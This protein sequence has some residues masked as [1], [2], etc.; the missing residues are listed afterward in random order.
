M[1][2]F[3]LFVFMI[4]S[5][6]SVLCASK[7]TQ[8]DGNKLF[9]T[10]SG[11]K[12]DFAPT[13]NSLQ[14]KA[15]SGKG[16]SYLSGV[17]S[18]FSD[19]EWEWQL[20]LLFNPSG[21][22]YAR[23]YVASD[24]PDL[25][26]SLNGYFVQ[27]GNASDQILLYRQTGT[28]LKKIAASEANRLN[29][30]SLALTIRIKRSAD[31]EWLIASKVNDEKSFT[32]EFSAI[33]SAHT[34][35]YFTGLFCKYTTTRREAF[36][37]DRFS[38]MGEEVIDETAPTVKGIVPSD[39]CLRLVFS[40][41]INHEKCIFRLDG[42]NIDAEWNANGKEVS[43]RLK[44]PLQRGELHQLH[45]EGVADWA[46]NRLAKRDYEV[47][48]D[49][50]LKYNDIIINEVLFHPFEDGEDYVEFYNRSDKHINLS[51][52][53]LASYK[54]DSLVYAAKRLP[55]RII[56]PQEIV[57]ITSNPEAVCRFY[58]CPEESRFVAIE[59]L[60]TYGNTKGAVVL[61]TT[62]SLLIDELRYQET[63]HN[64]LLKSKEGVALER[65]SPDGDEW[66]SA[67]ANV[68]Y[69]TPGRPN[70]VSTNDLDEISLS[71]DICR[72]Y[73]ADHGAITLA[74]QLSQPDY[75]GNVTIFNLS[76]LCVRHLAKNQ[77]LGSIGEMTWNGE[78]DNGT[79]QPVAPYIL[80]FE[81][82]NAQ[83]DVIRR[84][85]VCVV[86]R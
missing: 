15:T 59:R 63:M 19:A 85:F 43:L 10:W 6:S 79:L 40:E 54:S 50:E 84:K 44:R 65:I 71:N 41:R 75:L 28:S 86:G 11:S 69:G 38:A 33:D 77:L 13:S 9:E 47:L 61:T 52:L 80:L 31:G 67:S 56:A 29:H 55:Q 45:L 46:G 81:A 42:Q 72:P 2:L 60:P 34:N 26:G 64:E 78:N 23:L 83:G 39:S 4:V 27:V 37:F 1:R 17:C 7:E 76:G 49:D 51:N 14:L 16:A 53:M 21:S 35:C 70:S 30:D 66:T 73:Q 3:Y 18:V 32:E 58:D 62:D 8:F 24:S 12:N 5:Y 22:N 25:S 74:Y 57:V 48:A 20:R 82:H 68:G 36:F